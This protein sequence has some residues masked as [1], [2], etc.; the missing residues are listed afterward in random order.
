MINLRFLLLRFC[1]LF[2]ALLCGKSAFA[3]TESPVPVAPF[4]AKAAKDVQWEVRLLNP[5]KPEAGKGVG[6]TPELVRYR[7]PDVIKFLEKHW[8]NGKVT[9]GWVYGPYLLEEATYDENVI[10]VKQMGLTTGTS[11]YRQSDFPEISWVSIKNFKGVQEI[12]GVQCFRY[13]R[14]FIALEDDV[15]RAPEHRA[16]PSS[17]RSNEIAM[18]STETKLPVVH[19]QGSNT[20]EY[21]F[22]AGA[23]EIPSPSAKVEELAK[24]LSVLR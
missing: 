7:K 2:A 12:K 5:T 11:D 23:G 13:E 6:S 16:E 3:Q 9:R 19:Q 24:S 14:E 1:L 20:F 15:Q 17:S 22:G 10:E 18:I 8:P 21:K 4:V